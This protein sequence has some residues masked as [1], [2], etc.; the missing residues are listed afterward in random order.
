MET[1]KPKEMFHE[2]VKASELASKN[3]HSKIM[4]N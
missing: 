3:N 1:T 2:D 4:D